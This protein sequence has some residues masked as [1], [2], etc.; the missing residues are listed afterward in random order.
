[1]DQHSATCSLKW[2][3]VQKR[4]QNGNPRDFFAKSMAKY[5]TGF[6]AEERDFWLGLDSLASLT[7]DAKFEMKTTLVDFAGKEYLGIYHNF[8]VGDGPRY[9]LHVGEYDKDLSNFGQDV[10]SVHNQMSFS[11]KDV[12]QD[13]NSGGSC[14]NKYGNGG[15]WYEDCSQININGENAGDKTFDWK[16]MRARVG[17]G[18]QSVMFKETE[19]K[20]RKV[21]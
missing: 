9:T 5:R 13:R 16:L 2:I 6:G 8:S 18:G 21:I 10:F 1:M 11:T 4:G 3:L 12:D 14:S 17:E 20:I 7:R 15:W 19:I